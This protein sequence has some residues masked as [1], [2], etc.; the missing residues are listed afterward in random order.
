[1]TEFYNTLDAV[2]LSGAWLTIGSFDGVHR[3]HQ[4]LVRRMV[5]EAHVSGRPAVVLTFFPHPSVVLGR[6]HNPFYLSSPEERA[7][8]L[9][10]LGAD[11]VI[12][13]EFNQAMSLLTAT[14]FMQ[15]IKEKLD[16]EQL[17]VGSN[18]ALG[19]G[20]Q[21]DVPALT[22]I[23]DELGYQ[24]Q[25]VSPI[26]VDGMLISS[27]Q[28]RS[29]LAEGAVDQ[30]RSGLG[31]WYSVGGRVVHGD[32][33]GRTIGIP[34]ANLETWKERLLPANGVYAVWGWLEG[35]RHP[36]V[37]N[38]GVRPTFEVQPTLPRL[39]VLLLDL[40]G[41]FYDQEMRVDFVAHLR[42][43]QRFSSVQALLD[44]IELDKKAAREIL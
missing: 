23:G 39:E 10:G 14:E 40:S 37:A 21:G 11:V 7:N 27:T 34:T 42:S 4:A 3:G 1:M 12:T 25:V 16:L 32:G 28:I 15:A 2:H 36:G 18:F 43:E 19:R 29:W 17:W 44:Q 41:D 33:R 20:R 38:I 5:E 26:Q 31:R 13:L 30:A 24:V 6:I 9:A 22:R 35:E 8:L